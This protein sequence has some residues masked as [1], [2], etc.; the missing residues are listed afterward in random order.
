VGLAIDDFGTGYSSLAYLRRLPVDALK[1][2]RAFVQGLASSP[3]DGAIVE[4][5][6]TLARTL[7]LDVIA[8]GVET[9]AQLEALQQL[10][11]PLGQGFYWA[12][13]MPADEAIQLPPRAPGRTAGSSMNRADRGATSL[14]QVGDV[15]SIL[16]HELR[17][18]LSVI[19][20]VT[21]LLSEGEGGLAE[22]ARRSE[23]IR[24]QV[25]V[26]ASLLDSVSTA[27]VVEQGLVRLDTRFL[28]FG[29]VVETVVADH[30]PLLARA[31][32]RVTIE[33]AV[34]VEA[35]AA[36]IQQLLGNLLSNADK[37]S[38]PGGRIDVVVTREEHDVILSVRDEGPGIDPAKV[39]TIFRKFGRA[40]RG[41][42][43]MGLGLFIARGIALAHGGDLRYRPAR[44]GGAEFQF[45]LP[46]ARAEKS[47]DEPTPAPR[48][49]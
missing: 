43:G 28:D 46:A 33:G 19:S 35:D 20:L 38:P 12:H 2:D 14:A 10:G 16:D 41:A 15:L 8:E 26:I 4:A 24:R 40:D 44:G 5:V 45:I 31:T 6:L 39:G 48:L 9:L 17:S 47:A 21:D 30:A 13:P 7:G 37:F 18:P 11:C 25:D 34:V 23:A 22:Q 36:R 3:E 49:P 1:I 32:P 29:E 27:R 42:A